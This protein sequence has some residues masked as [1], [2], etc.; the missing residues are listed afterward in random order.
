MARVSLRVMVPKN[1]FNDKKL[2]EWPKRTM[3]Q[4]CR[5][6]W[7]RTPLLLGS[8]NMSPVLRKAKRRCMMNDDAWWSHEFSRRLKNTFMRRF[9]TDQVALVEVK[10]TLARQSHIFDLSSAQ[11]SIARCRVAL[12]QRFI[13][14]VHD[15]TN[16]INFALFGLCSVVWYQLIFIN[17][18]CN[19]HT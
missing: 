18:Y 16:L 6:L 4:W 12:C 5:R 15:W 3:L 8:S 9:S 11:L 1:G 14:R 2:G 17:I 13:S 7:S 19:M 10:A